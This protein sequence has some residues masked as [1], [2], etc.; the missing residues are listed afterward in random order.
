MKTTGAD[1][2]TATV[3]A[4]ASPQRAVDPQLVYDTVCDAVASVLEI[5]AATLTRDTAFADI[6]ADSL[7]L[8]EVAEIVEERLAGHARRPLR[9]PDAE[10]EQLLTLGEAVDY[11]R[12]L[13]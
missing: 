13:L 7:A 4:A 12:A 8:V 2:S 11:V 9:I 5:E 6:R 1:I 3:D 10:L